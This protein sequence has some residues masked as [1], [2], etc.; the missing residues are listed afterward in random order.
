M[1]TIIAAC[2]HGREIYNDFDVYAV[3]VGWPTCPYCGRKMIINARWHSGLRAWL[4]IRDQV[5]ADTAR[6]LNDTTIDLW[7]PV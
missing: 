1:R 5:K 4:P 6:F 3:A 7:K 2:E